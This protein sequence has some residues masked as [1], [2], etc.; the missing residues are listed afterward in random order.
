M[1]GQQCAQGHLFEVPF[2]VKKKKKKRSPEHEEIAWG[3]TRPRR[4]GLREEATEYSLGW[5]LH[6]R[7]G[8][9]ES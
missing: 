9:E 2:R 3:P 8:P 6:E 1:P 7:K 4:P 5:L